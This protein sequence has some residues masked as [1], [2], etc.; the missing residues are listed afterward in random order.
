MSFPTLIKLCEL[1]S[2]TPDYILL[3]K[4]ESAEPT[5]LYRLVSGID[6][7][8]R[9]LAE[10]LLRTFLKTIGLAKKSTE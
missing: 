3:G 5:E 10:E 6:E 8:Y 1:L 4:Q 7:E 9:P 2:T